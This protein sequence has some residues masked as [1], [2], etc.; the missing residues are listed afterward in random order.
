MW[1]IRRNAC[2]RRNALLNDVIRRNACMRR[3]A[4]KCRLFELCRRLSFGVF[5]IIG[6]EVR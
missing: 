2:K 3:N 1:V 4:R 5:P 6:C